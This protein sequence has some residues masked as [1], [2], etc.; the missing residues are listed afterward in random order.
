[1]CD[2]IVSIVTATITNKARYP[3]GLHLLVRV[4]V[5][6]VSETMRALMAGEWSMLA[7][8]LLLLTVCTENAIGGES[9]CSLQCCMNYTWLYVRALVVVHT[10][11]HVLCVRAESVLVS[12]ST[13]GV[14]V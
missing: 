5:W 3:E 7:T 13:M 14:Y 12:V 1:M 9:V 6:T 8:V 2:R 11:T 10:H 4:S